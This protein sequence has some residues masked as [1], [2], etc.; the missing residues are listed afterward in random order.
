MPYF[1][2]YTH[3]KFQKL[4]NVFAKDAQMMPKLPR[5]AKNINLNIGTQS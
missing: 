2:S 5:L 3:A 1:I 4:M